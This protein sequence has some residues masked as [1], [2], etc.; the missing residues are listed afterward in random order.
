MTADTGPRG[1]GAGIATELARRGANIIVNHFSK[2]SAGAATGI[3]EAIKANNTGAKAAVVQADISSI[4]SHQKLVDAA[5]AISPNRQI[6]ILVHNAAN[7][8]DRY[9]K[10]ID[11]DFYRAQTDANM[12]GQ[13]KKKKKKIPSYARRLEH[14]LLTRNSPYLSYQSRSP[15]YTTR[16]AYS[17]HLVGCRTNGRSRNVGLLGN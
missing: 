14:D 8:D 12:K 4:E 6:D 2:S 16:R 1:I 5:L 17:H 3:V 10:D 9:L 15:V 13:K 11:E 7:G